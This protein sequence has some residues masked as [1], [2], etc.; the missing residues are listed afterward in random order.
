MIN[1]QCF[2][3]MSCF[4][5]AK[6]PKWTILSIKNSQFGQTPFP[7]LGRKPPDFSPPKLQ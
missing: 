3:K 1:S 2:P 7:K 5:E 4:M 6:I